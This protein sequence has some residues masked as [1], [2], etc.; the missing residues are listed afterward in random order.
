[1]AVAPNRGNIS[2]AIPLMSGG[3]ADSLSSAE[4]AAGGQAPPRIEGYEILRQIS[5]GGQGVVYQAAQ[6]STRRNV[7]I[8]VLLDSW[9]DTSSA[10]RRFERE[11]EL[12]ANLK[13]PNI[14][15][16]FDSGTTVDGRLFYV[17]DYVPG[18]PITVHAKNRKLDLPAAMELLAVVCDAVNYAHQKGVIHRD[19]KPSNILVDAE[20]QAHVL[21]F[22]LAKALGEHVEPLNTLSG[23]VMGTPA[24]MS[25]EQARGKADSVDIRSDVYALG[26]ILYEM[27]TGRFPYPVTGTVLEIA[28]HVEQTA[29][30]PPSAA[31]SGAGGVGARA[32]SRLR[33]G[34]CPLDAESETIVLK[35]L[36]KERE[37]R[38]QSAGELARD[39]RHYLAG[40]PIEA[41]RDSAIYVLRKTL[42]RYRAVVAA[43][44]CFIVLLV[45]STIVFWIQRQDA[46][47]AH[48]EA[49]VERDRARTASEEAERN[50]RLAERRLA[51]GL[52]AAGD[53]ILAPGRGFDARHRYLQAW[54]LA[55]KL[56]ES[57]FPAIAG[58]LATYQIDPPPLMGDEGYRQGI[59]GFAGHEGAIGGVAFLPDGRH[60]LSCGVD[61]TIRLW[62]VPTGREIRR[63]AGHSQTVRA[64][65]V[66]PDGARFISASF[67][68][69]LKLWDIASGKEIRAFAGHTDSVQCV[70]VLPDGLTAI[71]GGQD[72]TIRVWDMATANQKD[73]FDSPGD[74]IQHV[75]VS[76]DG[77]LMLACC[78]GSSRVRVWDLR[79]RM[80][81]QDLPGLDLAEFMPDSG[82]VLASVAD[83]TTSLSLV[84]RATG[85]ML[86]HFSGHSGWISSIHVSPGGLA[87][88]TTSTDR[89]IKLWGIESGQAF[90]TLGG[91][92]GAV[93]DADMCRDQPIV[94]SGAADA[95]L[96]LWDI[97]APSADIAMFQGS[98]RSASALAFSPD[99]RLALS[100]SLG[101]TTWLWD[102]QTGKLLWTFPGEGVVE[103]I[104]L[105]PD[106]QRAAWSRSNGTI[107]VWDLGQ[108]RRVSSFRAETAAIQA[109]SFAAGGKSV[110]ATSPTGMP[111]F[112]DIE[113]GR[114][115]RRLEGPSVKTVALAISADGTVAAACDENGAVRLWS[116]PE[117][118]PVH[119]FETRPK[120]GSRTLAF[121]RNGMHLL[122][123]DGLGGLW[124]FDLP[125]KRLRGQLATPIVAAYGVGF[126]GEGDV[127]V[128]AGADRTL[129][130]W[131]TATGKLIHTFNAHDQPLS[132]LAVSASGMRVL[133]AA[134]VDPTPRMWDFSRPQRYR[135]FEAEIPNARAALD[136]NP[137]DPAALAVFGRWYAFRAVPAW[138]LELFAQARAAGGSVP[139][140]EMARCQWQLGHLAEARAEFERSLKQHDAPEF[141]L[142]LCLR[143][144]SSTATSRASTRPTN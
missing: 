34:R 24:Y 84:D 57:E 38:Y 10:R 75:A 102:V 126:L 94:I 131:E 5:R 63:F 135:D 139:A 143:A 122:A 133:T 70:A 44:G 43:V 82:M 65:A 137:A 50:E 96:K 136:R 31:W 26:V 35:A 6:K 49:L 111:R 62:H 132:A 14:I 29:P 9:A 28:R 32:G 58:V 19:L 41:R 45:T 142:K 120:A 98:S 124:V 77:A 12:V 138:A 66:L 55:R 36:A 108:A 113:S 101:G 105:S 88:L 99:G 25:P 116:L 125:A 78:A 47:R 119:A 118:T 18:E 16:V 42:S 72:G 115:L 68:K 27:L 11:V 112:W 107:D 81:Q 53:S 74:K 30:Q 92:I 123:G 46:R 22:G 61:R 69:T 134:Q 90:R 60:A 91:H 3:E 23:Q 129:R 114:E 15:T 141:Y 121:S 100:G 39:I 109:L 20:G 59:G 140:L 8:K 13:H 79:T 85:K 87:A 103:S 7:A 48:G 117:G 89:L 40:R 56:G 21:D 95:T 67:D 37:R 128:S 97:R 73:Q 52:I 2:G 93:G 76:R 127:F 71:S 106:G 86:K 130:L 17:M 4:G 104:A 80:P 51:E 144:V 110:L 54:D 1:M 33:P 64:I 83:W